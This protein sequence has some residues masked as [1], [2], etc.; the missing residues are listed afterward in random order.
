MIFRFLLHDHAKGKKFRKKKNA[1]KKCEALVWER[2][3]RGKKERFAPADREMP[4]EQRRVFGENACISG[5]TR[6]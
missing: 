4:G 2:E 1:D 5:W 3:K 6:I